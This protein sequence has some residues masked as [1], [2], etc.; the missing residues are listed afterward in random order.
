VPPSSIPDYLALVGDS[1]WTDSG[2]PSWGRSRRDPARAVS[3]PR[4]DPGRR[5]QWDVSLRGA[6]TRG[7]CERVEEALLFR[8]L[9]TLGPT[10]RG[11]RR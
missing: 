2:L 4:E 8:K 6:E 1:A 9:A 11:E 10:G 5:G 3:A 7:C